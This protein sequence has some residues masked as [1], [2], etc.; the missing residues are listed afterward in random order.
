MTNEEQKRKANPIETYNFLIYKQ[1]ENKIS[2]VKYSK[3][4]NKG[5]TQYVKRA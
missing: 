4:K 5:K 1:V 3:S 2:L